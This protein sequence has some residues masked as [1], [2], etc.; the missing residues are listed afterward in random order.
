MTLFFEQKKIQPVPISKIRKYRFNMLKLLSTIYY[1]KTVIK[2]FYNALKLRFIPL[3][4]P[5]PARFQG[6]WRLGRFSTK[7]ALLN[8]IIL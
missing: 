2:I 5:Q 8:G 3:F 1:F 4:I 7:T 6:R